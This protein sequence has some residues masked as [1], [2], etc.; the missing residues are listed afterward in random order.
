MSRFPCL[1]GTPRNEMNRAATFALTPLSAIY[2]GLV[3][4]GNTLYRRQIFQTHKVGAPVISVGNLTTGGTGKTP[5]VEIVARHLA[6]SERS[7]CV[8]TR[9][10]RR[11]SSGRVIVSDGT[12][13]L[14]DV[15]QAGDEAFLLA[16]KLRGR[17]AVV[18]DADR[19]A[20]ARWATENLGSNVFVLD[21]GFQHQRIARDLNIAV[22]D[23]TNPWGNGHVL[24]A[25]ALRE[26]PRALAR[27]DCVVMTRADDLEQAAKLREEIEVLAPRI[28]IF[29][30]RTKLRT[31]AG[32][33]ND[34]VSGKVTR[35]AAFCGIGNPKSFFDLL[36]RNAYSIAYQQAFRD[37]HK[38]SQND[39][40][41]LS[42]KARVRDA[43]ALVTTEKDAVKLG[44]LGLTIPVYVAEIEIDID[45]GE[46]FTRLVSSALQ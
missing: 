9:G 29:T 37:H 21:D 43:Q 6:N 26:S 13:V 14:A 7:V 19:V 28:P 24:P 12:Q 32:L 38:Y 40:D 41:T 25:G 5:I 31:L 16:Q 27:A 4:T 45:R 44:A 30:S 2:S 18:C 8:L 39:L 33:N 1:P 20:A 17:A 35:F 10:Y 22:I 36:T 11:E 42:H 15:N 3:A 34:A 23:A 46:E